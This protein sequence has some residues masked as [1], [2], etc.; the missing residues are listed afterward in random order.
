MNMKKTALV[1]TLGLSVGITTLAATCFAADSTTKISAA[2]ESFIKPNAKGM[3]DHCDEHDSG[4]VIDHKSSMMGGDM[5]GEMCDHKNS[6]MGAGHMSNMM[7]SHMDGKM[8][9]QEGGSKM[10]GHMSGMMNGYGSEMMMK[11]PRI[12]MVK[13]FDLNDE[14]RSKINKLSDALRHNNWTTMGLIM[15]ESAKLR[16]LYAADKRNPSA[17]GK[18][19]QKIFDLQRQM[20]EA[21][22]DTENQADEILTPEQRTQLKNMHQKMKPMHG[23]SM[24]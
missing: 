13:T 9:D 4:K 24:H 5:D 16:D 17:I 3:K 12:N 8:C 21:M 7:G 23:Y 10:G 1:L 11:S 2:S 18:N 14:Q 6:K 19:Y 20:I 15:D 22:I